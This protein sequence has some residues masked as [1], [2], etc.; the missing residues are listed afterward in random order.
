MDPHLVQ[1]ALPQL[2]QRA[3]AGQAAVIRRYAGHAPARGLRRARERVQPGNQLPLAL[4]RRPVVL[5]EFIRQVPASER[6]ALGPRRRLHIG[7]AARARLVQVAGEGGLVLAGQHV[8]PALIVGQ[9]H[10]H[11]QALTLGFVEDKAQHRIG[12]HP[13]VR[14]PTF[15]PDPLQKD[16]AATQPPVGGQAHAPIVG[17][18]AASGAN[19]PNASAC[20]RRR[21]EGDASRRRVRRKSRAAFSR[22][23]RT[24]RTATP[25]DRSG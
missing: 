18:Q 14:P 11:A 6:A 1:D 23:C 17:A 15:Q 22:G 21:R 16:L 19:A 10:V 12:H 9:A 3:V 2:H 24:G 8:P 5:L 4:G 20:K 13:V 25:A 7:H